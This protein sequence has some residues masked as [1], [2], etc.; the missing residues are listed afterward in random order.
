MSL[1]RS[2]K[3]RLIQRHVYSLRKHR[4]PLIIT[5]KDIASP[6]DRKHIK[7][8]L[9]RAENL[10]QT[11]DGKSILL[12]SGENSPSFLEEIGRLREEAF[13]AVG[14]GTGREAG[15]RPF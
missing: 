4:S 10:G 13:R 5:Q 11:V 7:H 2:G 15:H 9:A 6:Q 14:E 1:S 3:V 8:D 12:V